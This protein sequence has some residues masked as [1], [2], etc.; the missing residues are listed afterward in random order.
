LARGGTI[1]DRGVF[2]PEKRTGC[3]IEFQAQP[4]PHVPP[5]I[6]LSDAYK[7]IDFD[8][9]TLLLGMMIVVANLRLSGR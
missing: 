4:P 5:A 6:S 8:T 9:I 7:A 3:G 1:V 2:A